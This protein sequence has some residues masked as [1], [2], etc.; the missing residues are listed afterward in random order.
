MD[1][2]SLATVKQHEIGAEVNILSPVDGKPTDVFI[3]IM[4]ADSKEWRSAKK[5]QTTKILQAKAD[6]KMEELDYDA[7]DAE[8][9]AR[10]TMGWKGI[11]KD[12]KPY[13]FSYENAVDLYINSPSVV[14]QL[15]QFLGDRA[16][17]TNG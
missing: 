15:I 5:A 8:A 4:G 11:D 16:N 7:M 9:L 17:F 13:E 10:V 3:T 14:N 12:G 2:N 1:F 6:D